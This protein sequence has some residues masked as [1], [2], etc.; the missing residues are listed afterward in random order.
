MTAHFWWRRIGSA[1][2]MPKRDAAFHEANRSGTNPSQGATTNDASSLPPPST[3]GRG[4][5]GLA[6][7]PH[8]AAEG[9]LGLRAPATS[10]SHDKRR[11]AAPS[12][13]Q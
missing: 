9:A 10:D 3:S 11:K 13:D 8:G 5:S 6:P 1:A 4:A 7:R 12:S 2:T